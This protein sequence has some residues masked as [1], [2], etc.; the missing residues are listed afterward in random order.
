MKSL[1]GKLL[2]WTLNQDNPAE[3]EKFFQTVIPYGVFRKYVYA[4]VYNIENDSGEQ[5]VAGERHLGR[6]RSAIENGNYTPQVFN[7]SIMDISKANID[8]GGQVDFPLSETNKL[9]I[10]DGGTRFRALE[11]IRSSKESYKEPI[12]RLPIPLIVYFQPEKRKRDFINLNNGTKV[13][14]SHLQSLEISSGNIKADKL[15]F[16]E[17]AKAI[18]L[19]MNTDKNSPLCDKITYGN[20]DD[21]GR[22]QFSQIITDHAG[23]LIASLYSTSRLLDL[24]NTTNAQY[25][26]L[27]C[28]LYELAVERTDATTPGKL[29]ALPPSGA[30]G[31]VSNWISVINTTYYYLYLKKEIGNSNEVIDNSNHIVSALRVYDDLVAGDIGRRR[32]QNLS[33]VYAQKIFVDILEKDECPAGSHFGIPIPLIAMTSASSF[34]VEIL[35]GLRKTRKSTKDN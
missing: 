23:S 11:K 6:I 12:D 8:S 9:P 28:D 14:K 24:D 25:V 13:N 2:T 21:T 22:I 33:Q 29:L 35:P 20:K 34:N 7:L 15:P 5:R 26:Q 30:K 18:S 1:K 17:R 19:L 27:F 16:F 32:R 31:N 3:G 4:D 10:I